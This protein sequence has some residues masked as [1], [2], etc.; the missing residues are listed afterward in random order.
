MIYSLSLGELHYPMKVFKKISFLGL[1]IPS[2]SSFSE[3]L[4][5]EIDTTSNEVFDLYFFGNGEVGQTGE[6]LYG[7][8]D[9]ITGLDY[10]EITGW[11]DGLD[12]YG[13]VSERLLLD[14]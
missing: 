9:P 1:L 2:L 3:L 5:V 8:K 14:G 11:M 10:K 13:N 12:F 4:A 6:N 7:I